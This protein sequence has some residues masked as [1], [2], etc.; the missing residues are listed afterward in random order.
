M[1]SAFTMED[2]APV[3]NILTPND[4]EA[5]V[6]GQEVY[7][8]A[9]VLDYQDGSLS[10]AS[11]E[12]R[13][14][15]SFLLGSGTEFSQDNLL[16]GE[17]IITVKATNSAG[18][19]TEVTFSIFVNDELALPPATLTVGPDQVGWHVGDGETAMQSATVTVGN[20]GDDTFSVAVTES[21][22]W[23]SV[24]QSGSATPL[25]LTLTADPS[26]LES[27]QTLDTI[28]RVEGT[29]AS[30]TE[31]VMVPVSFSMGYD[32]TPSGGSMYTIFLPVVVKQ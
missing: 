13:D 6:F 24:S 28:L 21:A 27:G 12:W 14:Q 31:T 3:I 7:F 5:F 25:Q 8:A 18:L 2:K 20:S 22:P 23:L 11:I 30:G 15:T 29:T 1:T 9:E 10:G 19:F 32:P 16:I 4:G 17:N 26:Y